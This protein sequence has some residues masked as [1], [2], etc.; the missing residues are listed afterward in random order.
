MAQMLNL[1]NVLELVHDG[2]HDHPFAKQDFIYQRLER[3]FHLGA[4]RGDPFDTERA[5]EFVTER[6]GEIAFVSEQLNKQFV[7]ELRNRFT[8]G[9]VIDENGAEWS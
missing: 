6:F 1:R 4:K 7:H 9:G 3:I 5:D 8:Y 2:F